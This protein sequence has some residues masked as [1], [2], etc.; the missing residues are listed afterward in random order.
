MGPGHVQ[1]KP[2][3]LQTLARTLN[4]SFAD[5]ALQCHHKTIVGLATDKRR[6]ALNTRLLATIESR[7]H[8]HVW[9][10]TRKNDDT[11]KVVRQEDM[12]QIG[13]QE[14]LQNR[15]HS[16]WTVRLFSRTFRAKT[17]FAVNSGRD[18]AQHFPHRWHLRIL[19][20]EEGSCPSIAS[21]AER[22]S[23]STTIRVAVSFASQPYNFGL[24]LAGVSFPD[25]FRSLAQEVVT[26]VSI[27][28]YHRRRSNLQDV[29]KSVQTH[30]LPGQQLFLGHHIRPSKTFHVLGIGKFTNDLDAI[31][32]S[33][34]FRLPL[35][36]A[37]LETN[38]RH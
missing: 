25:D 21:L 38:H 34:K 5:L 32:K 15:T 12:K 18:T 28:L 29:G 6:N 10:R 11:C 19:N 13:A 16:G 8:R 33:G 2:L 36:P 22:A 27:F 17:A 9:Q 30:C 3:P 31:F 35:R 7:K 24:L 23:F 1:Q 37:T 4:V 14:L 20:T 26:P